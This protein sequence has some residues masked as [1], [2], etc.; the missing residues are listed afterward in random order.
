MNTYTDDRIHVMS[1][2]NMEQIAVFDYNEAMSA[3]VWAIEWVPSHY[4]GQLWGIDNDNIYQVFVDEDWNA[5]AVQSFRCNSDYHY[6]I[7]HDG[8]NLW[9]GMWSETNWYVVD[10]GVDE[11]GWL[12]CQPSE[13]T[14]DPDEEM[15][16]TL[17]INTEGLM[18]G[19]YEANLIFWSNDP[20]Y[21]EDGFA[22]PVTV[23][24]TGS[25]QIAA[26]W[27]PGFD[28]DPSIVNFNTA[29]PDIYSGIEYRVPVTILNNGAASLEISGIASDE[30]GDPVFSADP[31]ELTV[32]AYDEEVVDF[33]FYTPLDS[34]GEYNADLIISSN[35]G[36]NSE[37]HVTVHADADG[38]P[39]IAV[40]PEGIDVEM[41][42]GE[43]AEHEVTVSNTGDSRLNYG[44]E[45]IVTNEPERDANMRN[46]RGIGNVAAPIRDA[47]SEPDDQGY[48][49]RD[50]NEENGPQFEW[51]DIRGW[52]GVRSW[53]VDDDGNSGAVDLG[54]TFPFWNREFNQINIDSDGWTSFTYGGS[55]YDTYRD[56]PNYPM[57]AGDGSE[58]GNTIVSYGMDHTGMTDMWY[59]TSEDDYAVVMWS[60]NR[61]NWFEMLLY[62]NGL[63]KMQYGE[64]CD[65]EVNIGVNLGDGAHGWCIQQNFVPGNGHVIGFGPT[66]VWREP[67]ISIEPTEGEI[68]PDGED[69]VL[70]VTLNTEGYFEGTYEANIIFGS[71]D[72]QYEENGLV[73]PVVLDMIGE[74]HIA[75]EWEPGFD[76]D[77]SVV[78]FNT[79]CEPNFFTGYEYRIPV[80][81]T[82]LGTATLR[83]SDI[84]SDE[85]GE[86][87]FTADPT[88]LEIAPEEETVVDFIF[89]V[90]ADA[91]GE[92]NAD[93]IITNN[94]VDEA[95]REFHISVHAEVAEQPIIAINPDGIETEVSI[96]D[97]E[98]HTLT[99]SN[100]GGSDLIYEIERVILQEP[101]RDENA[102]SLRS[103]ER[104]SAPSRRDDAGTLI[105]EFNGINGASRYCSIVG[106]DRDNEM[107]WVSNYYDNV[108]AAYTHDRDY[109]N[110]EEVVRIDPGQCM[111]GT[112]L[113]GLLWLGTWGNATVNLY[114][115]EGNNVGSHN[116]GTNVYGLGSDNET[117]L[118]FHM[119]SEASQ[120]IRVYEVDGAEVGNQIGNINNH[121]A[122]HNN[123]TEYGLEWVP[124]HGD[125]PLWMFAYNN[126]MV[127]QIGV[128]QDNW[129]CFDYEDAVSFD[130]ANG[131]FG[132]AYGAVGHDG[133]NI[134]VAGYAPS[135]I[136]IYDD[137]VAELNWLLFAPD[138][139][140]L[141][142]DQDLNIEV[143]LVTEGLVEGTYEANLVFW[144]NDPEYSDEGFI[145]NVL[146]TT[147]GQAH[148]AAE[149]IPGFEDDPSV[150]DFN[151]EYD[152]NL[153]TGVNYIIP[154]TILNV[155]SA[156]LEISNIV[157]DE[158]GE[159][160][161]TADPT[162]L[163]IEPEEDAVVDFIFEA[164]A[165]APDDYS[166]D[167]II[168]CNDYDEED[169]EYHITVNANATLPPILTVDPESI[170]DD[171]YTGEIAVH[172]IAIGNEGRSALRFTSEV[173]ITGEPDR[174]VNARSLRDVNGIN[175]PRRDEASDLLATIN[176]INT[177]SNHTHPAAYDFDNNRMWIT[178]YSSAWA[179]TYSFDDDYTNFQQEVQISP[180]SCMDGAWLNG[181]YYTHTNGNTILTKWDANGQSLGQVQFNHNI[182]GSASDVEEG[183]LL[184]QESGN[185]YGIHVYP[186]D[187]ENNIG[188]QIGL[189][190]NWRQY[191]GGQYAYGIEWVP[192]HP[193]GQ[194]WVTSTSTNY[195]S[196]IAVDTDNWQATSTVQSFYCGIDANTYDHLAHD[197]HNIWAGGYRPSTLRVYDDGIEEV[198]WISHSPEEGEV[199]ADAD[200]AIIELTLNATGLAD[201]EYTADLYL[202][203]NDPATPEFVI[204]VT[205][206][207]AGA[208]DLVLEWEIGLSENGHA[209]EASIIDWN[210]YFDP[211]LFTGHEYEIPVMV[212]NIGV[213]TL[214]ISDISS[215]EEGEPHFTSDFEEA[216]QIE[217]DGSAEITL[218]FYSDEA[219]EFPPE[220]EEIFMVFTSDDPL[221]ETISIPVHANPINPPNLV[222]EPESITEE[223]VI[224][225]S[226]VYQLNVSNTGD[227]DLRYEIEKVIIR[228]PER[229]ENERTLRGA[230]R[231]NN[232]D[233]DN[234]GDMLGSFNGINVANQYCSI[235][236]WDS[237]A[238]AMWVSNYTNGIAAAYTHDANYENFEEVV[239]VSPGN[240]MDGGVYHGL[241]WMGQWVPNVMHRYDIEGNNVG[242]VQLP[243]SCYGLAF[244]NENDLMFLMTSESNQPIRVYEMDDDA[245]IG[246]QLGVIN[247]HYPYHGN[248]IEYGLEWVPA[249]GDAPLWMFNYSNSMLYQIGVDQD[250]WQCVD[251]EDAVSF[252]INNNANLGAA[253][254]A[255]GHDGE[256]IWA[257]GYTPNNI[258]IY[259][260][261]VDEIK[262]I[263]FEPE[264]GELAPDADIDVDVILN[265]EGTIE[266]TYE[267]DLVFWTNDP[268]YSEEG[269]AINVVMTTVGQA[270]IEA[271]WVPGFE[272]DPSI[273]NFNT[274]FDP[275]LY[276]IGTYS[277]PITI[278]NN[279]DATLR[280][281]DIVSDEDGDPVF[282]ADPTELEITPE[283]EAVIDFIFDAPDDAPGEYTADMI[284]YNN[285]FDE[286]DQ[287]LH[288]AVFADASSPP[289]IS[290]DPQEI[291]EDMTVGQIVN[292][293]IAVANEGRSTLRFTTDVEFTDGGERDAATRS[294]RRLNLT[295]EPRRDEVDLNGMMF[296][297]IQDDDQW[298][299]LDDVMMERDPLLTR[300]GENAN[301]ETFRNA[302]VWN[303]IEFDDY[304]AIVYVGNG[305]SGTYNTNYNQNLER[306]IEYIDGGG[307]VYTETSNSNSPIRLPGGF[308]NDQGGASNGTL[309]VS[310]Y[311]E[312]ENYSLFAE[313]CHDSQPNNWEY[314]ETIEGSSWLHSSYSL[315]QFDNAVNDGTIDW[316]QVIAVP[317]GSQYA[318]A[319]AYGI[320]MGTVLAVG[321]PIGHCWSNFNSEGMWGSIASEILYYLTESSGV[322]WLSYEPTEGEIEA[323]GEDVIIDVE[324][325]A[326]GLN[327]GNYYA[328]LTIFSNDPATPQIVVD[329]SISLSDAPDLIVEW[330]LGM[331]EG[332]HADEASIIDWNEY[333]AP[334]F[335]T[336]NS[337]DVVVTLK[338]E[339]TEVLNISEVSS[340]EEGEP[341]FTSD[342]EGEFQLAVDEEAE[343]TL[344]FYSDDGGEYPPDEEELF[345]VFYS[346][347]PHEQEL[348][349]PINADVIDPPSFIVDVEEITD[350][351]LNFG[352]ANH[353]I[354]I[355]ND[356][357][358]T[359]RIEPELE[360]ID[361]DGN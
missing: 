131:N 98:E 268:R 252:T 316:Y 346:D 199:E 4:N 301:Y 27:E 233:R 181:I 223:I 159:H 335:F 180:G 204:D 37:F 287:E 215:S 222:I 24:T 109:E 241:A 39:V 235:I 253:Y 214:E 361:G 208:P 97:T 102:R 162:E 298:G 62:D 113:N 179:R 65:E 63:V 158:D 189:I 59:W 324:L 75:A 321:H 81:I 254:G 191:N 28:E 308:N 355:G 246:Q 173:V 148:I 32:S 336:G 234:V 38:P 338:N 258:R 295:S 171:L 34:P 213:A 356:G 267:A 10:D 329:I 93:M 225:E 115:A 185:D 17:T 126:G 163:Q 244:D 302:S 232:P 275:D 130:G 351:L 53:T 359:L 114:D 198:I 107:M 263:V 25:P 172:E 101:G 276:T 190:N 219:T 55:D 310:P 168:S 11:I 348:A 259:D 236:G 167:M 350:E 5:E 285:D 294:L 137:G 87:V 96:P 177:A 124:E 117:S 349:I 140:S 169:Q 123:T 273:V 250:N 227:T 317:Q 183:L 280:I 249:H 292:R 201:G 142:P 40:D 67:W 210:A 136:R 318:G 94:D 139:G 64:G 331:G 306:F 13:G 239:R 164:P 57:N 84:V 209:D 205:M 332:G 328:E 264:S 286:E 166:A 66:S 70:I 128:D 245:H 309:V 48:E 237:A 337:Y 194:L 230:V 305:Q 187:D 330:E 141:E 192:Q 41:G 229:D 272:D 18:E 77:P 261:G 274:A 50:I 7:A 36:D 269:F 78:N 311:D 106:W 193:D 255:V 119:T 108:A 182:Y 320:G 129:Q 157:S 76:E 100:S 43:Q 339:G 120:P 200:P 61:S 260:D 118:I 262:W 344:S 111:D 69:D 112:W 31:S 116:F 238:E 12:S 207:V 147:V 42:T 154:V 105:A 160:V 58:H 303:D 270:H 231:A 297:V 135:N 240:S 134:W 304:D 293:E 83:I 203:T 30:D 46:L 323:D 23:N 188:E 153:F 257:A 347:D 283:N 6:A 143:T 243:T 71:N 91:P 212:S 9:Y 206:N 72:P 44:V 197:G 175:A 196:Q 202:F 360:Y 29:Y 155:G 290:V 251:Y 288:I 89:G 334:D 56:V 125:A 95:D 16:V 340:S 176:G 184:L 73:L 146:M 85:D 52:D 14:I 358:S 33:I 80:T 15:E 99:L 284:I 149:W 45:I 291:A 156:V 161:F 127:Y 218:F 54:F 121:Y 3:D 82:N 327:T 132:A 313:I 35:D 165:D 315:G 151:A 289:V 20:E 353:L 312:D 326:R 217:P 224:P 278:I 343:V 325:N 221:E 341:R 265:S 47:G 86:P 104:N 314:G 1:T 174:D 178:S 256:Y 110:F 319:I 281:S 322:T 49:W 216:L 122:Y 90:A 186:V 228:E 282:I 170:T 92:Y 144:T 242:D 8:E 342:V 299:W 266:G 68:D 357:G 103:A 26:E 307:A 296:A 60:G 352:S 145:I 152:P 300:N 279:G 247:N 248:T 74:A 51:V 19:A 354:A 345:M 79:Q 2:D 195:A 333:F 277:V 88:E 138:E 226:E 150:V 271:E 22:V 211:D 133:K 21:E 220:N